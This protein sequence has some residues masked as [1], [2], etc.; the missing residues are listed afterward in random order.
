MDSYSFSFDLGEIDANSFYTDPWN[1]DFL[2]DI[3]RYG[4][5]GYFD[6]LV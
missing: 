1:C 6:S 5:A 4:C 2:E 3:W